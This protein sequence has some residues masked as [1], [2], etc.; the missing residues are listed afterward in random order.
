MIDYNKLSPGRAKY[1]EIITKSF[2]ATIKNNYPKVITSDENGYVLASYDEQ[3]NEIKR[4][5]LQWKHFGKK[6]DYNNKELTGVEK[7]KQASYKFLSLKVGETSPVFIFNG[8]TT[9]TQMN[10]F[11]H[12]I[13]DVWVVNLKGINPEFPDE[14]KTWTFGSIAIFNQFKDNNI[15]EKDQIQIERQPKGDKSKYIVKKV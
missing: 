1:G 7:R 9:T 14:A 12:Q 11:S 5:H 4:Q 3:G 6:M 15:Q 13:E 2:K 10:N 8:I